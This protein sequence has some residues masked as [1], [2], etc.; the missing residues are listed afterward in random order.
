[1]KTIRLLPFLFLALLLPAGIRAQDDSLE[2]VPDGEPLTPL[3]TEDLAATVQDAQQKVQQ[4]YKDSIDAG[5]KIS[6]KIVFAVSVAPE[7]RVKGVSIVSST[8]ANK[9]FTAAVQAEI[10]KLV[11]KKASEPTAFKLPFSFEQRE[12]QYNTDL[13]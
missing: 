9:K 3:S 6:G 5:Q 10:R 8:I 11:F 13:K 12:T 4:M 1:M 7:G 2:P